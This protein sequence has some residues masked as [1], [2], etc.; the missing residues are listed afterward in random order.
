M[1]MRRL[2]AVAAIV[3]LLS[4]VIV[5]W[6]QTVWS[7]RQDQEVVPQPTGQSSDAAERARAELAS[8]LKV[9]PESIS[10]VSAKEHTWSDASLG[11]PEPG[12]MYAQMITAGHIVTLRH[13]GQIYVYHVAGQSV[14][15]NPAGR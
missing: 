8:H 6:G 12:M 10:I 3:V 7:D 13:D 5:L 9:S 15:L 11:L 1:S 2:F 4:A 14:K